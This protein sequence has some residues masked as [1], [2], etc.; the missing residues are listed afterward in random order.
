MN[1]VIHL[2]VFD[3]EKVVQS[4]SERGENV[5]YVCSTELT[6]GSSP[7]DVYYSKDGPHPKFGNRYFGLFRRNEKTYICD[8][9]KVESL[10]FACLPDEEMNLHYSQ[11]GH[12]FRKVRENLFIDG[13][14]GYTRVVGDVHVA[15]EIF[16][17]RD[18]NFV[19]YEDENAY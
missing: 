14:R 1:D 6:G 18:G 8:A 4:F 19:R 10:T 17:V 13:G 5:R 9:D 3:S 2:P 12:D 7:V 16:V 11:S 15:C